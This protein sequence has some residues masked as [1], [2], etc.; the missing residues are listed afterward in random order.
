MAAPR[1]VRSPCRTAAALLG[2]AIAL[3]LPG[4]GRAEVRIVE[5]SPQRLVIE[6]HDA[7]VREILDALTAQRVVDDVHTTDPLSRSLTG[8]YVGTPARVLSR[9]LDG[10]DHVIEATKSGL[11]ITIFPPGGT[12]NALMSGARSGSVAIAR[13]AVSGNVDLDEEKAAAA[14]SRRS[15]AAK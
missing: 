6:A 3:A 4:Y 1:E 14:A 11:E 7:D 8:T 12:A 10:Y 15:G 13:P 5:A 9:I 2:A